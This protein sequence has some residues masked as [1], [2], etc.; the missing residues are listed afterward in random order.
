MLKDAK[1]QF[2]TTRKHL[3]LILDFR[4]DIYL[5]GRQQNLHVQQNNMYD[6]KAFI[7]PVKKGLAKN[8]Q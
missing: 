8:I 7:R 4:I 2:A 3:V 1:L 6:G 5:K